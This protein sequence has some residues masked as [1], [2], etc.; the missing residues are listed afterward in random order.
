MIPVIGQQEWAALIIFL[1]GGGV[2]WLVT[3]LICR[4][5]VVCPFCGESLWECGTGNFKPRR[6]KIR[7]GVTGC[8]NCRVP[9]C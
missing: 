3:H 2:C 5:M 9:I 8:P 1:P 7:T 4:P 6:M